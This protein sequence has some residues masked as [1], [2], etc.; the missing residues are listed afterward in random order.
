MNGKYEPIHIE[1]LDAERARVWG[2]SQALDL[3]IC[4]KYGNLRFYSPERE[5]Y[6]LTYQELAD[7]AKSAESRATTA[8]TRAEY[9]AS[10]RADAV[11]RRLAH[12]TRNL[13]REE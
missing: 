2:Y 8:A 4:L 11:S 10:R 1:W 5:S 3:F 6:L 13:R 12:R 9:E 7:R